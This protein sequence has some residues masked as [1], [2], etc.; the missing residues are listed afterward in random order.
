VASACPQ[1]LLLLLL[2]LVWSRQLRPL[3]RCM[4]SCCCQEL[5]ATLLHGLPMQQRRC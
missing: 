3:L 2:L 4:E 5:R 1:L